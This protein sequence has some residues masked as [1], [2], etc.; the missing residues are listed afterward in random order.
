[1]NKCV[2]ALYIHIPFCRYKCPYCDFTSFIGGEE[3]LE[4][5]ISLVLKEAN[6]YKDTPKK[7][8]TLYLGGGTPSL[9]EPFQIEKLLDNLNALGYFSS[10]EEITVE[11]NP[12]DYS[13]KEYKQLLD[14]GVNRISIGIQSFLQK[15]LN[16]LGR[17][18]NSL[19]AIRSVQKAKEAGFKNINVDLIYA[20]PNQTP[21]DIKMELEYISLLKPSHVS[22]YMLTPY[23][24][25]PLWKKIKERKLTMLSEEEVY[26]I[27][28]TLY[29]GLKRLGYNRYE[30]SNWAFKGYE[31]KH[32]LTYWKMENFIGLGVSAC[33]FID[34]KRYRNFRSLE[35]YTQYLEK[36]KKPVEEIVALSPAELRKERIILRLRLKEGLPL[37]E[38]YII[39]SFLEAFFEEGNK[40]I[41]IKE[42]YMILSNEIIAEVLLFADSVTDR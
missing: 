12:E 3:I 25:T 14:I 22:A 34:N 31:C 18:H 21:E 42:E 23:K 4:E 33:G 13:Y 37:R 5:Y 24:Y 10:L 2:K 19:M 28:K 9:L 41:G 38:K 17:R 32:N 16:V 15:G 29:R 6:L 35:K 20:Y 26:T 27:Y 36:G 39:P 30:I 7:I 11:C 1:M 8:S 40:G